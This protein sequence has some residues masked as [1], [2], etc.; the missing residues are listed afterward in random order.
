MIKFEKDDIPPNLGYFTW[1]T[2]KYFQLPAPFPQ[3]P[4]QRWAPRLVFN[5][6]NNEILVYVAGTKFDF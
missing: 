3:F 2:L 5:K 4:G 1:N 6:S